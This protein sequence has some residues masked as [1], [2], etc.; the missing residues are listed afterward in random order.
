MGSVFL[1]IAEVSCCIQFGLK[2]TEFDNICEPFILKDRYLGDSQI[3]LSYLAHG[4][5]D[6]TLPVI[7]VSNSGTRAVEVAD[8]M[9]FQRLEG[10]MLACEAFGRCSIDSNF[11]KRDSGSRLFDG[12]PWVLLALWGWISIRGGAL[13]HG[14]LACIDNKLVLFLGNSGAGK[15]T[16]S[17]IAV[18]AGHSCL[19][20]ENPVLT[21]KDGLP[22]VHGTPWP[23]VLGDPSCLSGKLEAIFFLRHAQKNELLSLVA[24]DAGR[25]ILNHTRFF[26]WLPRTIPSTIET[27]DKTIA[28]IPAY[29][30][31]FRPE[32]SVIDKILRVL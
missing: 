23:G 7:P 25:R 18:A 13:L 9:L 1:R 24:K 16:L 26:N 30:L 17:K 10:R 31:G 20:E 22:L 29:D 28:S 27:L 15:T 32:P 19:T 2:N 4:F 6:K 21:I 3:N 8:G 14:S 12:L 11:K 5:K